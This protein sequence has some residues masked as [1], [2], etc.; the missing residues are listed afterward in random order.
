VPAAALDQYEQ[1]H[2]RP[3]G[4]HGLAVL[5]AKGLL[6]FFKVATVL[7]PTPRR[8]VLASPV[9]APVDAEIVHVWSAMVLAHAPKSS[10]PRP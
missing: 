7:A 5:A 10:P 6:G 2:Q 4:R 1:L 9:S 3:G 8:P